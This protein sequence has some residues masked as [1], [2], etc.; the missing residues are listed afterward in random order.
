MLCLHLVD[1]E[2]PAAATTNAQAVVYMQS[3]RDNIWTSAARLRPG[4]KISLQLQAWADVATLYEG[5]KRSELDEP[6]LQLEEP[7]W[8]EAIKLEQ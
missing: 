4:D 7:C 8:G 6:E 5:L 3:M 1:I 2:C